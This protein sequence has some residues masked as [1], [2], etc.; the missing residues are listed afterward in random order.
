MEQQVVKYEDTFY[1]KHEKGQYLIP[2][3]SGRHDWP[4][5]GN[6]GKVRGRRLTN[7]IDLQNI[8]ESKGNNRVIK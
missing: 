6:T 1:L 4:K 3:E 7:S 5:L 8:R 2:A